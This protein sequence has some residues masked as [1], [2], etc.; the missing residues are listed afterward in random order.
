MENQLLECLEVMSAAGDDERSRLSRVA[1]NIGYDELPK[2]WKAL[3]RIAVSKMG[4]KGA[5]DAG[6]SN[7]PVRRSGRRSARGKRGRDPVEEVIANAEED[8]A[9]YR[10]CRMLLM[11]NKDSNA[12]E[13][14]I[15]SIRSECE[16]GLHPVWERLAREAPIFAELSR[17]PVKEQE[18][19]FVDINFWS[20]SAKFDPINHREVASWLSIEPPFHLT[21]S[22]RRALNVLRKEYSSKVFV[23]R[24]REHLSSIEDEGELGNFLYGIIGSSIGE[25]VVERFEHAAKNGSIGEVAE[26]HLA[27][28]KMRCGDGSNEASNWIG[29]EGVDP[30]TSSI[31]L[32]AWKHIDLEEIDLGIEGFPLRTRGMN[33]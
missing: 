1:R 25:N 24:V 6:N 18:E 15:G 2:S 12:S 7:R 3:A 5:E 22:Q 30:L 13:S 14:D 28:N 17:F 8:N 10:L 11:S 4:P 16:K 20:E 23:K 21:G 33:F 32:E 9:G 19:D 29:K 27:L 26:M 31:V